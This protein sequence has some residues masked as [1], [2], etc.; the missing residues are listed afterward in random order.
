[1]GKKQDKIFYQK[2]NYLGKIGV[3]IRSILI[4]FR[5]AFF[6]KYDIVYVQREAFMLG[7]TFFERQFARKSKL[8]FDFDD[9]IWIPVISTNNQSLSF[10]KNSSKTKEL[11]SL[12]DMVFAGNAYLADYAKKY[13]EVVKIVPTTLDTTNHCPSPLKKQTNRICIGW[14]GSFSTIPHFEFALPILEKLKDKYGDRIY[15]KVIGD[16]NYTY[17]RLD[18]QGIA[19]SL[20]TEIEALREFDI[21]IMPL[22]DDQWTKGKCGF[23]GLSFMSLGLP[24]ILSDVGVNGDIIEDGTNGFLANTTEEWIEKLSLLVENEQLRQDLGAAG[25]KTI[26]ERYSV[27]ANR[28]QYV[29]YFNEV[30]KG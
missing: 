17:P 15:F 28:D 1:L 8:I 11:I 29:R 20:D 6:R 4:L 7:T 12:A 27:L 18:I 2:G 13:N 25:R 22:P 16:A 10:L 19:W 21:G 26:L 9:A 23:K 30:L 3:L 14:S 5:E 24:V